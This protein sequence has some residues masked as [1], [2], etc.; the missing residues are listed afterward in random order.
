MFIYVAIRRVWPRW[1]LK[2]F[3]RWVSLSKFC[4]PFWNYRPIFSCMILIQQSVSDD[5]ERPKS[6]SKTG[7]T[8]TS[9]YITHG[10]VYLV[11]S[12]SAELMQENSRQRLRQAALQAHGVMWGIKAETT[13]RRKG[14]KVKAGCHWSTYGG[15]LRPEHL[16][17]ST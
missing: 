17:N 7:V 9:L 10:F 14:A 2:S 3:H 12:Y 4:P 1:Y 6:C 13:G 5:P 11:W 15:W 8:I 16:Q